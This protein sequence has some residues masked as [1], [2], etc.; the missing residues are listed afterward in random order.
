[1]SGFLNI[2]IAL[3][4]SIIG[5]IAF[6]WLIFGLLLWIHPAVINGLKDDPVWQFFLSIFFGIIVSFFLFVF[7]YK[8]SKKIFN[9]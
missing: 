5:G 7:S 1:M 9:N 8:K 3:F 6:V 4:V 2:I